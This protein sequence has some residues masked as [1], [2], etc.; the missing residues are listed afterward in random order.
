MFPENCSFAVRM[1][2]ILI[3]LLPFS[4][5]SQTTEVILTKSISDASFNESW[6]VEW[7]VNENN[8]QPDTSVLKE[9]KKR[10]VGNDIHF[11]VY[12]GTWCDD[13]KIHVPAWMK[14][15]SLLH[16]KS[17]FIGVNRNKEC[18]LSDCSD[19]NIVYLPTIVVVKEGKEIGRIVETPSKSVEADLLKIMSK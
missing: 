9:L 8:Y 15:S 19:W 11:L 2:I 17:E 16:L 6:A 12:L 13:S 7:K 1:K 10:V 5:F 4:L 14:I 18:P 3:M